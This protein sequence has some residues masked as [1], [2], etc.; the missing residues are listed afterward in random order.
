[1]I[2]AALLVLVAASSGAAQARGR[3]YVAGVGEPGAVF[4]FRPCIPAE[5]SDCGAWIDHRVDSSAVVPLLAGYR[6]ADGRDSVWAER[7]V[8]LMISNPPRPARRSG[9]RLTDPR[10]R[11]VAVTPGTS[12]HVAY[13]IVE[14]A[15]PEP[16]WILMIDLDT[17]SAI[18]SARFQFK[19]GGM[20]ALK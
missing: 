17:H 16:S 8:L 19:P 5:G 2:R 7:G 13:A 12:G 6:S 11:F 10:G 15:P 4:E 18:A 3:V 1:M 9:S 14:S 20:G